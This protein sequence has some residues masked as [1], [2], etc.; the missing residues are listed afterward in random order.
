M[1]EAACHRKILC[2]PGSAD[3]HEIAHPGGEPLLRGG[4]G[5]K[6]LHDT[7]RLGVR[8]HWLRRG[9]EFSWC[10]TAL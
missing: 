7:M 5:T 9:M 1:D 3:V 2:M 6:V 4:E 10:C 8:S